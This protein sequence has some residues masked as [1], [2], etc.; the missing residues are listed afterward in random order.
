MK[1]IFFSTLLFFSFGCLL[2]SE[3]HSDSVRQELARILSDPATEPKQRFYEAV[4]Y[5]EKELP[6]S[7]R[8]LCYQT[9]FRGYCAQMKSEELQNTL[10]ARLHVY[11]GTCYVT[12]QQEDA[13]GMQ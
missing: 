1:K 12:L 9:L 8:L 6:L 2:A 3:I 5:M 4:G 11:L 7:E 10:M 13:A